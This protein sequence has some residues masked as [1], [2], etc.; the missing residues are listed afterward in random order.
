MRLSRRPWATAL[1][2]VLVLILLCWFA[3]SR[4]RGGDRKIT[5]A[6]DE[7]YE[8]VVRDMIAPSPGRSGATELVFDDTL[9]GDIGSGVAPPASGDCTRRLREQIQGE[10]VHHAP[11]FDAFA[12]KAYRLVSYGWYDV[13]PP[14]SAVQDFADK[15]C[16][17][18]RDQLPQTFHTDLHRTLIKADAVHFAGWPVEKD[19]E[20]PFK[21]LFPGAAGIISFSHVGFDSGR[22]AAIVSTAFFCGGLCGSGS[23]YILRKGWGRWQVI[24]KWIVWVS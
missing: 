18:H 23:R 2:F 12:D 3:S 6:E 19:G 16:A 5:S 17:G 21:E 13:S 8:A 24:N 14:A 7:V 15:A 20:K 9:I 1:A 4:F 22:R 10:I 11:G